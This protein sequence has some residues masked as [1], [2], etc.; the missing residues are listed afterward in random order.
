VLQSFDAF[1]FL[2]VDDLTI[3]AATKPLK[4][5]L[6]TLDT[7]HLITA[8]RYRATPPS[9]S[10]PPTTMPSPPPPAPAVSRSSAH[11]TA[12]LG[13]QFIRISLSLPDG[14]VTPVTLATCSS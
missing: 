1:I 7:L 9:T 11:S 3:E 5:A 14:H 8:I 6:R 2:A 10:S 12:A 4:H 13:R